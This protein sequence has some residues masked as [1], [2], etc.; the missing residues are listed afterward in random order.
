MTNSI[1]GGTKV[2][3]LK[4]SKIERRGR[5]QG[6]RWGEGWGDW[7]RFTLV[8]QNIFFDYPT[9]YLFTD[10]VRHGIHLTNELYL[11]KL[12]I[13]QVISFSLLLSFSFPFCINSPP[14]D[15]HPV[16]SLT[17]LPLSHSFFF[18]FWCFINCFQQMKLENC[19]VLCS[20]GS[21]KSVVGRFELSIWPPG[22]LPLFSFLFFSFLFFSF[23]FFSFLFFSF[24]F[25]SFLSLYFY[26]I[27]ILSSFIS[28]FVTPLLSLSSY[29]HQN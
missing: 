14:R 29:Q 23:L 28:I 6:A 16:F 26:F 15:T 18:P 25:F 17:S 7:F 19:E 12:E 2:S 1:G 13:T 24:L 10:W 22:I 27:S 9:S 21:R 5:A 20:R 8:G 4:E 3:L 11:T